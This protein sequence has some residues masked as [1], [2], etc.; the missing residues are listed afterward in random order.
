MSLLF[1]T[2]RSIIQNIN[3]NFQLIYII[4]FAAKYPDVPLKPGPG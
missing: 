3:N 1:Q 2:D 4:D